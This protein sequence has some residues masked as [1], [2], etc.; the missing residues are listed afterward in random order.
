MKGNA[1]VAPVIGCNDETTVEYE[2]VAIELAGQ[3]EK[4]R[5]IY[6]QTF[7]EGRQRAETWPGLIHFRTVPKWIRYGSF[8]DPQ[9]IEEMT[10]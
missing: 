6:Y 8:Q 2:W 10:F 1:R 4:Y 3:D 9:V 7:P 5:E